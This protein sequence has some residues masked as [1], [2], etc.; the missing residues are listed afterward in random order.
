M[1]VRILIL[2]LIYFLGGLGIANAANPLEQEGVMTLLNAHE[3][4]LQ[5]D[6]TLKAARANNASQEEEVEKAKAAFLPQAKLALY[7]GRSTTDSRTPGYLGSVNVGHSAYD[8]YD[9]GL[10]I[11]Q[12]IFNMASYAQYGQAKSELQKNS[13]TLDG[14]VSSLM[15]RVVGAYLDMLL[16]AENIQYLEAQKMSID[17]QLKQAKARYKLG[18]GTITEISEAEA[19]FETANA[20]EIEYRNALENARRALE[21]L[22]GLY[23]V[24][25]LC[26]DPNKLS[27]AYPKPSKVEEWIESGLEKNPDMIADQ[28]AEESAKDEINKNQSGHLPTL[29]LVASRTD[30]LSDTNYTIGSKYSTSSIGFQLNVPLYLGGYVNASVRQSMDKL[31]EVENKANEHKREVTANIRKYFNEV[32]NGVA[33]INAFVK[34][35]KSNEIAVIGT[36][37]GFEA[38]IRTNVEVLNAQEKLFSAKRDLAK[39]RYQLIYS[40]ILLKQ[41]AGVLNDNEIED[42][43]K[44]FVIPPQMSVVGYEH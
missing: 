10:S 39:E 34:S 20:R 12:T 5:Y 16:S 9:Y 1:V 33:R 19:N 21:N 22:T 28:F 7:Q 15:S 17:G 30:S 24:K 18:Y 27:L 13:A 4:A 14:V 32:V 40:R 37:K 11:R 26:L 25:F 42:V 35:V 36:Q 31:E 38:G 23:P 44:L 29:D 41:Y 43:S 3:M 6:A 2:L 8:S